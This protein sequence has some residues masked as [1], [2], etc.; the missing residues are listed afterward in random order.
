MTSSCLVGSLCWASMLLPE[1]A[2]FETLLAA[3]GTAVTRRPLGEVTAG[4]ATFPLVAAVLGNPAPEW[5]AVAI[6]GGVHGLERIGSEVALALLQSLVSRLR[7][8]S[9]LHQLLERLR[10]VFLPIVNP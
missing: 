10:I 1:L 7:W 6:V 8:D 4:D 9:T 5:P 2:E 3:G